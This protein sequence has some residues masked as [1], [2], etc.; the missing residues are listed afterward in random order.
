MT[1]KTLKNIRLCCFVALAF[2]FV[3][4]VSMA[5]FLFANIFGRHASS[6]PIE[7]SINT[8]KKVI[9]I[10]LY[11]VGTTTMIALCVKVVVNTINGLGENAVFPKSNEKLVFWIALTDFVRLLGTAN[12]AI[13]WDDDFVLSIAPENVVTPFFLLFFAFM[14]KVA[15]D[16][17]EEN[18]LTI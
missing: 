2:C 12:L 8:F 5:L 11:V 18:N 13:L 17:V 3:L 1:K 4:I 15:A 9:V 16:A 14:Y 10:T 6:P 7:W